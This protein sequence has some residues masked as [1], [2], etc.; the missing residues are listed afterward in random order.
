MERHG[1]VSDFSK[2]SEHA[3][4]SSQNSSAGNLSASSSQNSSTGSLVASS[5]Q[6][7]MT[8]GSGCVENCMTGACIAGNTSCD[9]STTSNSK[10]MKT[11]RKR[12]KVYCSHCERYISK[13]LGMFIIIDFIALPLKVGRN[14]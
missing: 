3:A 12:E 11:V 10:R 2:V 6:N 14:M 8:G 5:S 7:S 1:S 13:S 4:S 9:H